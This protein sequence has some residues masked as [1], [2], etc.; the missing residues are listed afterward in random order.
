MGLFDIFKKNTKESIL[1]F[2]QDRISE[3]IS[4]VEIVNVFEKM[5]SASVEGDMII[6]ETG[7][8]SFSGEPM[9]CFSLVRQ[10][11]NEEE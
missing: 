3:T 4:L 1:K 9:F 11:P 10:F 5:C 6:F 7:T 2:L 8:Y